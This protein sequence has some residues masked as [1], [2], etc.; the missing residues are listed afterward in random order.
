MPFS[1]VA[2]VKKKKSLNVDSYN[3]KNSKSEN[4]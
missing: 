4:F 1:C 3:S 2:V